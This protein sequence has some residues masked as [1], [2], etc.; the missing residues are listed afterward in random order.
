[1]KP[2][3]MTILV[4]DDEK[5]HL[6]VLVG[7]LKNKYNIIIAKNGKQ[8]LKKAGAALRPDLILLD[9]MMPEMDGFE[10]CRLLK[11]DIQ[12]RDIPV[13]FL[14]ALDDAANIKTGFEVGGVDYIIKPFKGDEVLVRVKTHLEIQELQQK[15][16]SENARFK[17]LSEAAFE[18]I[19]IHE[20]GRILNLNNQAGRLLGGPPTTFISKDLIPHF[21]EN[22]QSAI[23]FEK[24]E[25]CEGEL[26]NSAGNTIPVEIRTKNMTF[27]DRPAMVTAIRDLSFKRTL[28]NQTMA[29]QKE[30]FALKQGL[31]DRFKFGEIIGRSSSMQTVYKQITQAAA[32]DFNVV[33]YG[34]S[35]TGK[36]LV[37]RTI[38]ELSGRKNNAFVAVNCGAISESLFER[39]FF[40]HRRGS[41]TSADKNQPGFFDAAHQGT[42]FLDELAELP[43]SSQ[44]KLLRVLENGEYIPLGA[45]KPK[46]ADVRLVCATNQ[47]LLEMVAQKHFRED[48]FFRVHVIEIKIPPLRD[49]KEDI[50]LLIDFFL[51]KLQTGREKARFSGELI[52]RLYQ[53]EWPGNVR[54]LQNAV[55]RFLATGELNMTVSQPIPSDHDAY[56]FQDLGMTEMLEDLERKMIYNGLMKSNW[57]RGQAADLLKIP[58]RTL[59]RKMLKYGLRKRSSSDR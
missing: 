26:T 42:L 46:Q 23:L 14:S 39:E 24:E 57:H 6:D 31:Q 20:N 21:P 27:E 59:Q 2:A 38:Y 56:D 28:E 19:F 4:V 33:I 48:L 7:L 43:L 11:S 50:P 54:E 51:E 47:N 53:H 36:E 9:V 13:I 55:Q 29:L 34:E 17:T 22:C 44:V 52:D 8:A 35:G 37:A 49:R 32:S 40:G 58:R 5:I 25:V 45:T 3:I 30:N 15:L 18:G 1:M 10:A 16:K 12:T 41:F